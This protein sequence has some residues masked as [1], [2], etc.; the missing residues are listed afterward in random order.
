MLNGTIIEA[1]F[2][3][4]YFALFTASRVTVTDGRPH[5]I[6]YSLTLHDSKNKRLIGF[7]NAHSFRDI[8]KGKYSRHRKLTKWDH[9]H[10]FR[11][12]PA[13][14]P[15]NYKTAEYLMSDFWTAVNEV[16]E[17]NR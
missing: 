16:I 14:I 2:E 9:E 5:G 7:D 3:L 10:R 15:Y 8:R 17:L 6:K 4:G 11:G 1:D 12:V 13:I